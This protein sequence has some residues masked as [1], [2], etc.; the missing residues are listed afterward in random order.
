[1]SYENMY[2]QLTGKVSQN[3]FIDVTIR[4]NPGCEYHLVDIFSLSAHM[5]GYPKSKEITQ[6]STVCQSRTFNDK[7]LKDF[8]KDLIHMIRKVRAARKDKKY[9]RGYKMTDMFKVREEPIPDLK[10]CIECKGA[11]VQDI[12]QRPKGK[13]GAGG[14]RLLEARACVPCKIIYEVLCD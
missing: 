9:D 8:E 4:E 12:F 6:S 1:M 11:I 3:N 7:A 10:N 14:G 5:W 13:Q 2:L